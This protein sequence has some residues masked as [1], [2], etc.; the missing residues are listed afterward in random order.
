M[1]ESRSLTA[2]SAILGKLRTRK[3]RR[4]SWLTALTQWQEE[5]DRQG[6]GEG[7]RGSN[8]VSRPPPPAPLIWLGTNWHLCFLG[9]PTSG[10]PF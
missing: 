10:W 8:P 6:L 1:L 3:R 7:R 5:K 4:R 2:I 9:H